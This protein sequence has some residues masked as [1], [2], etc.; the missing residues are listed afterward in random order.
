MKEDNEWNVVSQEDAMIMA[1]VNSLENQVKKKKPGNKRSNSR[2]KER[3]KDDESSKDNEDKE[4]KKWTTPEWKL[5]KPKP[6]EA[7]EKVVNGRTYYF[8]PKCNKGNGMWT[9]HKPS[10]HKDNWK[11]SKSDK[12][13]D[14][15]KKTVSFSA[16]TKGGQD[17]DSSD[18]DS[19][20][21]SIEVHKSL[22][23]NAKSYLAQLQN[24]QEG[25]TQ[26]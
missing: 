15:K 23:D 2:Q 22:L 7:Q 18:D 24:F 21:P 19:T 8:C 9:L 5:Q 20:G 12:Q 17:N 3:V 13:D 11:L 1:L 26:G 4:K 10:D 16:E 14:D 25:G 6:G